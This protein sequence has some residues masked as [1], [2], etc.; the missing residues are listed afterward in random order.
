MLKLRTIGLV[1]LCSLYVQVAD[2]KVCFLPG[3]LA[4]DGC[5]PDSN[6]PMVGCEGFGTSHCSKNYNEIT[7]EDNGR[8][9]YRCECPSNNYIIGG[10]NKKYKCQ[11][12][13]DSSCGC[14]IEDTICNPDIYK[15]ENCN[16]Y[17][18]ATVSTDFC[19]SPKDGKRYYKSCDCSEEIYKYDCQ[20]TGLKKPR[21][22]EKCKDSSGKILYSYCDCI[23]S[24]GT[25]PCSESTEGCT[26]LLSTPAFRGDGMG[27]CYSCGPEVCDESTDKHLSALFCNVTASVTTDCKALGY[28]TKDKGDGK[29]PDGESGI[30][31]VFNS[32]FMFCE[33][34]EEPTPKDCAIADVFYADGTCSSI[35]EYN[36]S[37]TAVGV[38]YALSD[39]KGSIPWPTDVADAGRS[40]HGRV[41]SL[42]DLT[43]DITYTFNPQNPYGNT[44]SL[45]YFGLD[46]TDVS[47]LTNYQT[48]GQVVSDIKSYSNE[49]YNG[50]ENTAKLANAVSSASNCSNGAYAV[51]TLNYNRYCTSVAK[52]ILSFYP[53]NVDQNDPIVGAGNWYLPSY[54]ELALL[55]GFDINT[56][57]GQG[58]KGVA[59]TGYAKIN[60]TLSL[61]P[62]AAAFANN[63][64][65]WASIE[66]T[67]TYTWALTVSS[68]YRY[69]YLRSDKYAARASLEF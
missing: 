58:T 29:C 2:A 5:M 30:K 39:T 68:G 69:F 55:R 54:G 53:P 49:L 28:T 3:V 21:L 15:Y 59:G 11:G 36:S 38:V 6:K 9:Y 10:E 32:Q 22:A 1:L 24:W 14:R 46:G 61:L 18:G 47:E 8:T 67:N 16:N 63:Q 48:I 64:K 35:E 31:C 45:M 43:V 23:D 33:N 42:R 37:K 62:G 17:E 40:E 41:I 50:K 13:Y 26:S 52:F 12:P 20:E 25:Q 57:S 65:Y 34:Y 51:G 60:G 7:C 27:Y 66:S 4:S 44:L 56:I 19:I